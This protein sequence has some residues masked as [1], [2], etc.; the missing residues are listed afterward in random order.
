M[1]LPWCRQQPWVDRT[2]SRVGS[3]SC[4]RPL[5]V[6]VGGSPSPQCC[7]GGAG[8]KFGELQ[9]ALPLGARGPGQLVSQLWLRAL[10]PSDWSP[11]L[12]REGPLIRGLLSPAVTRP[13]SGVPASSTPPPPPPPGCWWESPSP[14][15][16][17]R[18]PPPAGRL[19]RLGALSTRGSRES[20][21]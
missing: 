17:E 9:D 20:W 8:P 10:Q 5:R 18:C 12:S 4:P 13:L 7:T 11:S 19:G 1:G 6:S 3:G 21:F 15:A 14:P 2:Q 16:A